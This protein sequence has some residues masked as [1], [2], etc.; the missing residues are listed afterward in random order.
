MKRFSYPIHGPQKKQRNDLK[1]VFYKL[2]ILTL[3]VILTGCISGSEKL[4]I[5][6]FEAEGMDIRGG[7]L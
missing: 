6:T 1:I 2:G 7:M 4:V 3:G 5:A